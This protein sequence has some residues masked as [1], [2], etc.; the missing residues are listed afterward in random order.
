MAA[1]TICSDSP[2]IGL[3]QIELSVAEP[4]QVYP[5]PSVLACGGEAA[6]PV[7]EGSEGMFCGAEA[8]THVSDCAV[9]SQDSQARGDSATHRALSTQASLTHE[10]R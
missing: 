6:A 2:F 3:Q 7:M 4:W 10:I 8:T 1:V 5:W 9:R